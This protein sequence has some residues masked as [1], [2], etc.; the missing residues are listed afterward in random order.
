MLAASIFHEGE[1]T[2]HALKQELLGLGIEL[3]EVAPKADSGS[4]KNVQCFVPSIDIMNGHAVQLVGGDPSKLKV[5]AGD[6]LP[7]ALK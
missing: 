6:P 7:L 4:T 1:T 5:D 2:V 3:R